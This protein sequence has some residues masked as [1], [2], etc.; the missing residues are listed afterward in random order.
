FCRLSC[1]GLFFLFFSYS[2]P[3]SH[4]FFLPFSRCPPRSSHL[5]LSCLR[6][7]PSFVR[8][9]RLFGR[10]LPCNSPLP[11]FLF[12]APG[13]LFHQRPPLHQLLHK[14]VGTI[15]RHTFPTQLLQHRLSQLRRLRMR[16]DPFLPGC[17]IPLGHGI[18][19]GVNHRKLPGRIL[20][21]SVHDQQPRHSFPVPRIIIDHPLIRRRR[22]LPFPCLLELLPVGK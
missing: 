22:I 12:P 21:L 6:L 14:R 9:L 8:L 19:G 2:L 15:R 3:F 11:F 17:L 10:L 5:L 20:Q 16:A 18:D 7:L 13:L 4:L 1:F